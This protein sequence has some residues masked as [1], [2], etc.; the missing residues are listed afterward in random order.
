MS[1]VTMKLAASPNS[2]ESMTESLQRGGRLIDPI[3]PEHW[4]LWFD[5]GSE[6]L[7]E[8]AQYFNGFFSRREINERRH[9]AEDGQMGVNRFRPASVQ[10]HGLN[11]AA[12]NSNI[13]ST[14]S[15][16]T[17]TARCRHFSTPVEVVMSHSPR[18]PPVNFN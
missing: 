6:G 8:E 15:N 3:P 16:L 1:L 5:R 18:G 2:R 9:S 11:L 4:R 14:T 13:A 17:S 10:V 7:R 12:T